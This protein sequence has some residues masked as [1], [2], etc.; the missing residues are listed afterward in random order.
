MK[1]QLMADPEILGGTAVLPSLSPDTLPGKRLR[2]SHVGAARVA[3]TFAED[4]RHGLTSTPKVL[5]P[6]YFYDE[7]GSRL[8][9]AITAL[10]EYYP[11]R[12]EAEILRTHAGEIVAALDGPLWLLE[13]GSGDGQKTRLVIEALLARQGELEYVPV[14]ISESAVEVSSRALLLSYPD[15]RI[16]GYVGEYQT[17]LRA[18]RRERRAPGCTL[19]LFLGSTLGNLDPQERSALLRDIRALLNPGEGF[20]LGV[21][22][23][24]PESVLIPAYDDALGVTAAFNLNL[25]GRINRELEGEFDLATFRHR[26]IYNREAGRI[27][28]HLESRRAQTVAIRALSLEVLFAAGETIHTESSYKFDREQVAALAADT[29]FELWRTWTDEAGRFASN[30]LVAR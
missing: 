5:Y 2:I 3:P 16:A 11:T 6:K 20:L 23:K 30:L 25:L 9:E 22:L 10:P 19:V 12:A 21:D 15:L 4:V 7:L 8:F 18:I 17:A 24:K 29:G 13:L 1:T 27:E 14:D 28:M 26:A